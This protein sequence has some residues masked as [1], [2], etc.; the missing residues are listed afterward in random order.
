MCTILQNENIVDKN[1]INKYTA[2]AMYQSHQSIEY[3]FI[4]KASYEG[5]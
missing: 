1:P 3:S 4:H 5:L 2:V